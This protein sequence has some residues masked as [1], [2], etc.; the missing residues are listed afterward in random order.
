MTRE[1][2]AIV[3]PSSQLDIGNPFTN[4][5]LVAPQSEEQPLS[6]T[7]ASLTALATCLMAIDFALPK[8]VHA[9]IESG[10]RPF[11]IRRSRIEGGSFLLP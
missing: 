10:Q 6:F 3:G 11:S 1:T 7:G 8:P 2:S 5:G 9:A 4:S